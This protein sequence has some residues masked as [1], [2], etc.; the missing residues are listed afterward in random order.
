M[1]AFNRVVLVLVFLFLL[2]AGVLVVLFPLSALLWLSQWSDLAYN[3][4]AAVYQANPWLFYVGQAAAVLGIV[5]VFGTLILLEVWPR[6]RR[7]VTVLSEGGRIAVLDLDSVAMRIQHHL[8]QLADV[9]EARPRVSAKGN[10]VNVSVEAV[11]SP[12]VDVPMKTQEILDVVQEVVEQRM[13]LRLG[14]ATVHVKHTA[15][16]S[17]PEEAQVIGS[18]QH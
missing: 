7:T 16:P 15:Y 12:D 8:L 14:R 17:P 9:V 6:G 11:T 2:L 18:T 3:T 13:G 10:T 1:N 4:L 5:L